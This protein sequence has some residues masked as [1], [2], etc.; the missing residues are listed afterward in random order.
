MFMVE[1]G[2]DLPMYIRRFS[3]SSVGTSTLWRIPVDDPCQA[4]GDQS[5][6]ALAISWE[7]RRHIATFEMSSLSMMLP[8]SP[9]FKGHTGCDALRFYYCRATRVE[10]HCTVMTCAE[11]KM[12]NKEV[13][14]RVRLTDARCL[15]NKQNAFTRRIKWAAWVCLSYSLFL[16]L[17]ITSS[18][19]SRSLLYQS[20]LFV[21]LLVMSRLSAI[22]LA[23]S[24]VYA[25]VAP[26][27]ESHTENKPLGKRWY[28]EDDHPV[29]ALFKRGPVGDGIIYPAIG[30]PGKP[31]YLIF[32]TP[33]GLIRVLRMVRR[34]PPCYCGYYD[35]PPGLGGCS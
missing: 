24:A 27:H 5:Y 14:I 15:A 8:C 31:L 1:V 29:H 19:P 16:P 22:L 17:A 13:S 23:A 28:H 6:S 4:G 25:S 34:L 3:W 11:D 30:T 35:A 20:S 18:F 26:A 21:R 32:F 2:R 9:V 12:P 33:A 7:T 10:V